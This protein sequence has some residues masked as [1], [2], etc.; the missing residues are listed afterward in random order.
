[1]TLFFNVSDLAKCYVVFGFLFL[2][3]LTKKEGKNRSKECE[4]MKLLSFYFRFNVL[5][6]FLDLHDKVERKNLFRLK[7]K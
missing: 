6:Q 1:M 5:G 4:N 7:G 3:H 2:S